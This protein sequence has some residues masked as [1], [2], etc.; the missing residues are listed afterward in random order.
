M[1][2]VVAGIKGGTGKTTIAVHLAAAL[3]TTGNP[4]LL[5]DGDE[6]A[7]AKTWSLARLEH[8]LFGY[9]VATHPALTPE[10]LEAHLLAHDGDVVVDVG[11]RDTRLQR[12][13]LASADVVILPCQ[14]SASDIWSLEDMLSLVSG[15]RA[16]NP[17]V[18]VA[19]VANRVTR[20]V[21]TELGDLRRIVEAAGYELSP[22][23]IPEAAALRD[24]IAFGHTVC[25]EYH[26]GGYRARRRNGKACEAISALVLAVAEMRTAHAL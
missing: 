17:D 23:T 7:S 22:V 4:T 16:V 9:P 20:Y 6:Q 24:A 26:R 2:V 19:V 10:D 5:L 21:S 8:D 3:G 18:R 12:A 14:P 1:T 11:G 15:A 25:E 13:A